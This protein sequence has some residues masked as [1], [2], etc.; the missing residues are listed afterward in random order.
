MALVLGVN[1]GF[2]ATAPTD[3]P[4]EGLGT[5]INGA[6]FITRDT[7]PATAIKITEIGW[8]CANES[9]EAD[10][11]LGLYEAD[12]ATVPGEAGTRKEIT[13]DEA[14]GTT[15][16]W[17]RITVDWEIDPSTVYWLA[18]G[19]DA[20]SGTL[21]TR[22]NIVNQAIDSSAI[23]SALPNPFGGGNFT[24]DQIFGIYALYEVE[25]VDGDMTMLGDYVF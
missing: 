7:S 4:F 5:G 23:K 13:S 17:K 11:R 24:N 19:L 16:G 21:V 12:G 22:T 10:F 14:K 20:T 25:E 2:V 8:H 9:D 18:G 1:C 15:S 3:N 6:G